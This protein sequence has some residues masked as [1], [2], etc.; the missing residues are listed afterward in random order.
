M[1]HIL[2]RVSSPEW[3]QGIYH[4]LRTDVQVE[5]VVLGRKNG[6]ARQDE[7]FESGVDI[8]QIAADLVTG[9]SQNDLE[10]PTP[11]ILQ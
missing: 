7:P 11:G 4:A 6:H 9:L 10:Q 3:E 1:P 2:L 5:D 8:R